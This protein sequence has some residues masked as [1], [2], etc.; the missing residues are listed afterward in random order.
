MPVYREAGGYQF[1]LDLASPSKTEGIPWAQAPYRG[2][3]QAKDTGQGRL[4][5]EI[6]LD[7]VSGSVGSTKGVLGEGRVD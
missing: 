1:V 3:N 7:L 2:H 5:E 4:E 6:L